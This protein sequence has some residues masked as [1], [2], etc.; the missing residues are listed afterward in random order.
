ML[1]E[2]KAANMVPYPVIWCQAMIE[3]NG[4]TLLTP[5]EARTLLGVSERTFQRIVNT[6]KLLPI[7]TYAEKGKRKYPRFFKQDVTFLKLAR[8]PETN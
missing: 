5:K 2:Q 4:H 8:T 3:T 1:F 7:A 6:H